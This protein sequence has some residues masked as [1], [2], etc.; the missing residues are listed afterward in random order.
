MTAWALLGTGDEC[1][2]PS[3]Q[4]DPRAPLMILLDSRLQAAPISISA[5]NRPRTTRTRAIHS[6]TF[7]RFL[8][9]YCL[10]SIY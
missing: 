5:I 7:A 3:H 2:G 1:R 10:V 9:C 6:S 8:N 4:T